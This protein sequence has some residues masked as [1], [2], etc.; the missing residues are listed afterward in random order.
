MDLGPVADH[1]PTGVAAPREAAVLVGVVETRAGPQLLFTQRADHLD[2]HPG[3][4]SFPGGGY[5]PADA[6]LAE[7]ARREA[8]EEVGLEPTE[9]S[10]VGRLDDIRTISEYSIR[11]F[12][13][14]I[15]DRPYEPTDDEVA[16]IAILPVDALTDLDNYET[17]C[18]EH[19]EHGSIQLHYFHVNGY[20]VWGAT[21][22]ILRQFLELTT[23]WRVP[24]TLDCRPEANSST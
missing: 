22:R 4:M 12:V 21:A 10:L 16:E 1:D 2:D 13:G 7:T 14:R 20:T 8:D 9:V 17:E 23:E 3:Q 6:D 11:P 19:P 15:P 24:Q 5:E 18:R